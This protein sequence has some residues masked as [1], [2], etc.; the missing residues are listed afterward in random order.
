MSRTKSRSVRRMHMVSDGNE[1]GWCEDFV[2]FLGLFILIFILGFRTF[3]GR[4]F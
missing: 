1:E 2:L 4:L 3:F